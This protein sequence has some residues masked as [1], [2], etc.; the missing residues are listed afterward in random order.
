MKLC[1]A[2]AVLCT[3]T[4]CSLQPKLTYQQTFIKPTQDEYTQH[5]I[6]IFECIE[7]ANGDTF[8]ILG[9]DL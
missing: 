1:I 3:V 5:R 6:A 4:S 8:K 2:F 7:Q 9:C